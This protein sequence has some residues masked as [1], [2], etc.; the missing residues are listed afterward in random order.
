MP[1]SGGTERS[2]QN[3][4]PGL[5]AFPDTD[6][7]LTMPLV[8]WGAWIVFCAGETPASWVMQG[9]LDFLLS[10]DAVAQQLLARHTFKLVPMMNPDGVSAGSYR[11][12][13]AGDDLNRVWSAPNPDLHPQARGQ[14]GLSQRRRRRRHARVCS[15]LSAVALGGMDVAPARRRVAGPQH[16]SLSPTGPSGA[17]AAGCPCVRRCTRRWRS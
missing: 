12:N 11:C 14:E 5:T 3:A 9:V 7:D 10:G 8:W 2:S 17:H 15:R 16:N 4:A 13:L 6:F 1:G